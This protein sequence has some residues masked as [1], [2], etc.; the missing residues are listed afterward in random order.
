MVI[1]SLLASHINASYSRYADDI[2]F[3]GDRGITS[4]I[5]LIKKV[6]QEERG[7]QQMDINS[8]QELFVA[9]FS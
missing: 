9:L 6:V 4:Y 1:D 2:T 7:Q 3:S 5:K 8:Q